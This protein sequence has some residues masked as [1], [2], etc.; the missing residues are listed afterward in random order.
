V[1]LRAGEARRLAPG[2]DERELRA[3]SAARG[4]SRGRDRR[5]RQCR[6]PTGLIPR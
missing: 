3:I 2:R 6:F 4:G 1:E 5:A